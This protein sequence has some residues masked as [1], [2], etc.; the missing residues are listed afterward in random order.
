MSIKKTR[1]PFGTIPHS[2]KS[3]ESSPSHSQK[4]FKGQDYVGTNGFA[5]KSTM[6]TGPYPTIHLKKQL[7]RK[8]SSYLQ[9]KVATRVAPADRWK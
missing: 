1:N 6:K 4:Q 9:R 5:V 7:S 2:K 3:S 8:D